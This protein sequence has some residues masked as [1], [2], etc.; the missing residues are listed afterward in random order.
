MKTIS[1]TQ[2]QVTLV[3]D[4]DYES[5]RQHKWYAIWNPNTKS[6]YAV[7]HFDDVNGKRGLMG[8]H[9]F[10]LGAVQGQVVDH[11]N[12]DT[13]DNQ[14]VNLKLGVTADNNK[15]KRLYSNNT[16]GYHGITW[17]PARKRWAVAIKENGVTKFLGR[18]KE[19]DEA[20]TARQNA[21]KENPFHPNHG[22]N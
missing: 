9:R 10:I 22:S 3:D 6:F 2:G 13:L 7:R 1:L 19:L 15:N 12:H 20:I 11:E 21:E 18:F 14:R 5:L 8:M 17:V 16:S 4:E